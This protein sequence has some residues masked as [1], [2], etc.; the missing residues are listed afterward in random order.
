MNENEMNNVN[1]GQVTVPAP[2]RHQTVTYVD[3]VNSGNR[4]V[5]NEY[6]QPQPAP[7]PVMQQSTPAPQPVVQQSAPAPQPVVQQSV[8]APQ[9]AVVQQRT[10]QTVPVQPVMQRQPMPQ[11]VAT[12]RQ[13][14]R[15][16]AAAAPFSNA[17]A[18]QQAGQPGP[19]PNPG[20]SSVQPSV[21]SGQTQY[22]AATNSPS[23]GDD[24]KKKKKGT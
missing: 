14:T 6:S 9:P 15:P 16:E 10:Q 12:E 5:N 11:P 22:T 2:E 7:Q 23:S 3:S 21:P 1:S 18:M 24:E 19:K 8:P 13:F 20:I 17:E 4:Y